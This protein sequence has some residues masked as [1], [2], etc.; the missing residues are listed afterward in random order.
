MLQAKQAAPL[1]KEQG[2]LHL[3]GESSIKGNER[4]SSRFGECCDVGIGPDLGGRRLQG[5]S[6]AKSRLDSRRFPGKDGFTCANP[7]IINLPAL[8][9][10][11]HVWS[12]DGFSRHQPKE[13]QL[14]LTAKYETR[15]LVERTKP[16]GSC[17]P[18]AVCG[19]AE[20]QPHIHIRENR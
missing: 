18:V 15:G 1:G 5:C 2:P 9:L 11:D 6:C 13:R 20:R 8:R 10:G 4:Q 7:A 3:P 14:R 16:R 19:V 12:K 17:S